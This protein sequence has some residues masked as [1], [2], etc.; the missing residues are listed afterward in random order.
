MKI[1]RSSKCSLQFATAAKRR[2]LRTV[3]N[4]YGCVVNQFISLFWEDCPKKSDLLKGVVDL[5]ETWLS[6]R[7]RKVAA[8]EAIDMVKSVHKI[9]AWNQQQVR[10][11]IHG[12]ERGIRRIPGT[13]KK[14]RRRIQKLY[15]L[16]N[17]KLMKLEMMQPRKPRHHKRSMSVSCT[18]ADLQPV[19]EAPGFDAWLHL[20]SIGSKIIMDLPVRFHRHFNELNQS[21]KRLNSYVIHEDCVQFSFEIETGPKKQ[22]EK[23][24]GI[25]T[26]INKLAAC[27]DGSVYG[28][29]VKN[30]I[31][32][33]KRCRHGSRGHRRAQRALRQR[34]DETARD[35]ASAAD[36]VVVENLKGISNQTGV[37]RRLTKNIRRSI[38]AWNQRYWLQRL[39]QRCERN[40]VSFRTVSASYTSRQCSSCGSIDERNRNGEKFLCLKCCHSDDADINAARNILDRFLAGPYGAGFKT[41]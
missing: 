5:P 10:N 3:L 29:D 7:L 24:L 38:G 16:R 30:C 25:D 13:T 41:K 18:I 40:R 23:V 4:E 27:S 8:R 20:G 2:R 35:A 17:A 19:R 31:E 36:L 32:R 12:I 26:G 28:S 14:Q 22:V 9:F 33:M 11:S 21:A 1:I 37:R 39:E 34:I 6:A 15:K